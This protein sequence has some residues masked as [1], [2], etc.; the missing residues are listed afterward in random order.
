M[1]QRL[2]LKREKFC[3]EFVNN[4]ENA[5]QAYK[6]AYNCANMQ[7]TTITNNAYKLLKNNDII[8]MLDELKG[9]LQKKF[10]YTAEQS[11]KKLEMI[12]DI[13]LSAEYKNLNAYLKA[14]D[15]I[16]KLGGLQKQ[17]VDVNF[18]NE[19]IEEIR[20]TIVK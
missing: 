13:A 4:T 5:T 12:Q 19:P 3:Q 7:E 14:E 2:T 6:K 8:T 15:L 18:S 20:V 16:Q 10:E 17:K 11:F 9:Q 1:T